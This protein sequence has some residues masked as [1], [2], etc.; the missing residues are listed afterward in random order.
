M[1]P[2]SGPRLS[3]RPKSGGLLVLAPDHCPA[4]EL[5]DRL[6]FL[7]PHGVARL[8]LVVLVVRVIVLR[9]A[10]R[11]L[12]D[13]MGEAAI[14]AHH[15]RLRLLVADDHA[16]K[17]TFRHEYSPLLLLVALLRGDGLDPGDVAARLAHPRRVLQ[18]AGGPLEAQV[19]ALLLQ[20][21][22]RIV[23]LVGAHRA[24]IANFH[25]GHGHYSAMRSTKR[26][27][28]G[29][30]AAASDSASRAVCTATPSISKITRPGLT[31]ATH[32]SGEPLPEPMRTS[33]GFF[34]TG[35]SGNTRIQTRPARFMWRVSARRAAS[36]WRAVT[37]SGSIAFRPNWPKDN[38]APELATPW[39]RPLCAFRNFVFFGCM[40]ALSPQTFSNAAA[41]AASRRG[42]GV[43]SP[44]AIRLSWAIGSCSRISPLKI[45]TLTPQV[46]NV[47]NA[48]ATP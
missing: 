33:A 16:L 48:V 11:L 25:L 39:I 6:A 45:Q 41:Q 32:N 14:D 3:P 30:L 29:S 26:V 5:G 42:R 1:F 47:V 37:R 24:D 9:P 20:I 46:P 28:I 38:V 17:R 27:L 21:D 8:E 40:M 22:D 43:L 12:V 4:L 13:R 18:L 34:D 15:N 36:I 35:T 2:E 7:D 23:H 19:E 31:R 10:D 44:S